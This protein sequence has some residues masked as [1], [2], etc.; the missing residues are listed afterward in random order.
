[1]DAD[2]VSQSLCT[3][4]IIIIIMPQKRI[5]PEKIDE[6]KELRRRGYTYRQI[7]RE[8]GVSTGKI[9]DICE[10][11]RPITTINVV[12]KRLTGLDKTMI[13]FEKQFVAV[14]DRLIEDVISNEGDFVCPNCTSDFMDFEDAR[15]PF[16]KCPGC[17]YAILFGRL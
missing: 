12:D 17:G 11:E 1:M 16:M 15:N 8:T 9:A 6:I 4:I 5:L 3:F 13:E 2:L 10:K 7:H 14:R